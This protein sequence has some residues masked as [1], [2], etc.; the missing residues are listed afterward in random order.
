MTR[1]RLDTPSASDYYSCFLLFY[2]SC[3]HFF[4]PAS[5]LSSLCMFLSQGNVTFSCAEPLSVAVTFPGPQ[6]FLQ[7][8][9]TTSS[10]S[11]GV[12]VGFQFRTWNKAG[13][14]LTFNLL[15]Q[16]GVVWLF[17]SEARLH[18]KINTPGRA[19]LEL[20]TGLSFKFSLKLTLYTNKITQI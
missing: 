9:W 18:L 12:T 20:S 17:L 16:G 8:P 7:L 4:C 2:R 14:L 10:P 11:G 1:G 3:N 15:Q 6:S 5:S 13:L 19:L